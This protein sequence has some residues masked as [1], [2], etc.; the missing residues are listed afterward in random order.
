MCIRDRFNT[1]VELEEKITAGQIIGTVNGK[2]LKS[3]V[4]GTITSI[5]PVSY[6]HLI[7]QSSFV[8]LKPKLYEHT[9]FLY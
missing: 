2:E 5:A 9:H 4:D 7:Q 6:T 3:P 8:H 1:A